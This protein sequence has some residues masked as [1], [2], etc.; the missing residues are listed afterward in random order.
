[1]AV[2][3]LRRWFPADQFFD[4]RINLFGMPQLGRCVRVSV[5]PALTDLMAGAVHVRCGRAILLPDSDRYPQ[6]MLNESW[7]CSTLVGRARFAL[8]L[9]DTQ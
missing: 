5:E 9:F 7:P 8:T 2:Y 4:S 6:C 3:L 1:M